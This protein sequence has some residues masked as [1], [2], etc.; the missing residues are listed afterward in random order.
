MLLVISLCIGI[1]LPDGKTETLER[2]T[3]VSAMDSDHLLVLRD[4]EVLPS[5]A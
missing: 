5:A 2:F 3:V 1:G 4:L